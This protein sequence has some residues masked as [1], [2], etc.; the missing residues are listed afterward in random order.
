VAWETYLSYQFCCFRDFSFLTYWQL[1]MTCQVDN[2]TYSPCPLILE[3]MAL[4]LDMSI[5]L[6]SLKFLSLPIWQIWRIP[7][8]TLVIVT[9]IITSMARNSLLCADVLLRN[10]SVLTQS[11]THSLSISRPG[12]LDL[13]PFDLEGSAHYCVGGNWI[14]VLYVTYVSRLGPCEQD[15]DIVFST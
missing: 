6:P 5:R 13:S 2:V 3:I 11:L 4:L 1:L 12:G 15:T 10:Y 9:P 14:Y 7:L 8:S